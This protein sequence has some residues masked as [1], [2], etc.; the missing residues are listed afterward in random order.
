MYRNPRLLNTVTL[1]YS[2]PMREHKQDITMN[3]KTQLKYNKIEKILKKW[4]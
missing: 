2:H 4:D 3:I 1:S